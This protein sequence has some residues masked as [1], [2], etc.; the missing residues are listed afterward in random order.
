LEEAGRGLNTRKEHTVTTAEV[1][2]RIE[3]IMRDL[4][5]LYDG[6]VTARLTA[7]EVEQ[8]DSLANVQLLVMVEKTFGV[9]FAN[10]DIGNLKNLGALAELVVAKMR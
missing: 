1:I 8:W 5:D 2:A 10:S 7:K 9:Q 3:P 4:F 6:P